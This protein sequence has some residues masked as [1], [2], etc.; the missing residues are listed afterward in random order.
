[1]NKKR[2]EKWVEPA[3]NQ[4]WYLSPYFVLSLTLLLV[5]IVYPLAQGQ[6][7]TLL[8]DAV[9]SAVLVSGL[10]AV[11]D[12]KII[13]RILAVLLIPI[14]ISTWVYENDYQSML[15]RLSAISTMAY[16]CV[17]LG[18][19]FTHVIV[20]REIDANMIFGSVAVYLLVGIIVAL[21]LLYLHNIDPGSVLGSLTDKDP[22]GDS[23]DNLAVLLYFSIITLTSVGYGDMVPAGPAAKSIAMFTGI[24]G[25]LYVAILVGKLVGIY[26]AQV[27]NRRGD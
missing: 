24:F 1:M 21:L 25:Q 4:P 10:Y 3:R 13:F 23:N 5:T 9:I 18:A 20:A 15:S 22:W 12:K 8:P 2:L 7:S 19:V 11:N 26:T 27:M 14:L 6:N 17:I 16:L